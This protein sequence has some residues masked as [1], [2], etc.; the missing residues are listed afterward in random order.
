MAEP[1]GDGGAVRRWRSG[2]ATAVLAFDRL[3][4]YASIVLPYQS[5][6]SRTPG[7]VKK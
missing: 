7:R 6:A 5:L 1:A 3:R 4:G 2:P